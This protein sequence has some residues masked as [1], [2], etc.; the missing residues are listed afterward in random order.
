M[1]TLTEILAEMVGVAENYCQLID[2]TGWGQ[3]EWL[4]PLFSLMPRLHMAVTALTAYD[5]GDMPLPGVD[6]DVRF[7]LYSRLR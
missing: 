6:L 1:T 7:E 5:N 4:E 2:R 3:G